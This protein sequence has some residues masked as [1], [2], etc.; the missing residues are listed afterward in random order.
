MLAAFNVHHERMVV[1]KFGQRNMRQKWLGNPI[2]QA[3]VVVIVLVILTL[4][5]RIVYA[6]D[7]ASNSLVAYPFVSSAP[8]P[9]ALFKLLYVLE[10]SCFTF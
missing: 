3:L 5:V 1:V 2:L 4:F 9:E 8:G 7:N 10:Y 6:M